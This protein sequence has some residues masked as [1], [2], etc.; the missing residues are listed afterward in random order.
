MA[1][2]SSAV[3]R[4]RKELEA[5][6]KTPNHQVAVQPSSVSLLEWHFVLH[7]LPEDCPFHGG[8]YHGRLLFPPEYPYAPPTVAMVT[9][10]G[11]LETGCRLCL[12]MTDYHPESWN[13]AWS[14]ETI[15]VGL[16]SFFL[17]ESEV[18]YGVINASFERRRVL[19]EESWAFNAAD[20]EF[21]SLFPELLHSP[22]AASSSSAGG[23]ATPTPESC[24]EP[25]ECWICRDRPGEP[26]INPCA[27]RG[28][29]SKVHQT[30]VER[31]MKHQRQHGGGSGRP[32]CSVCRELYMG[33]EV[34][35]GLL[36]FARHQV[37]DMLSQVCRSAMLIVMLMAFQDSLQGPEASLPPL[38]KIGVVAV[39]SAA[40]I[41]KCC[42]L[43]ASLPLHRPPPRDPRLRRFYVADSQSLARHLAE[44]L[45]TLVVLTLWWF[46]GEITFKAFSPFLAAFAVAVL[47]IAA[48]RP[49]CACLR[50]A[51]RW[52]SCT[53]TR[54][55][56]QWLRDGLRYARNHPERL[57]SWI[58]PL[59][60]ALHTCMALLAL[61][62]GLVCTSNVPVMLLLGAHLKFL[63]SCLV[64]EACRSQLPWRQGNG[65]WITLQMSFV[66]LYVIN[67]LCHFPTGL[68]ASKQVPVLVVSLAWFALLCA[69]ALAANWTLCVRHF[70][71]WQ[72]QHRRFTLQV[73]A[74][75]VVP[76]NRVLDADDAV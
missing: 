57:T 8:C 40:W 5:I 74:A 29:M 41:Y 31:W 68:G 71:T 17:S 16:V 14:A 51:L 20:P 54:L 27:C 10:N 11:R 3:R 15:L 21:P 76:L 50:Q 42:L 52:V 72:R 64:W 36:S 25:E 26:L 37:A 30:C 18:G 60:P 75:R 63:A 70:R 43:M 12:S 35:P 7:S 61:A 58:H 48:V 69:A 19:A 6:K 62:L 66:A 22:N 9:P 46:R 24:E 45:A 28:S 49:S 44:S 1:A 56:L 67:V 59:D 65:W 73:P 47:N 33:T 23:P 2:S 39:F 55:P 38:C 53:C 13:P 34:A 32:R 4:L